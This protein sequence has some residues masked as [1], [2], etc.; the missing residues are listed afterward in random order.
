MAT[1]VRI[2][3]HV[4]EGGAVVP[5]T[6]PRKHRAG[7]SHRRGAVAGSDVVR[8]ASAPTTRPLGSPVTQ[9][10]QNRHQDAVQR[11]ARSVGMTDEVLERRHVVGVGVQSAVDVQ[12]RCLAHVHGRGE[13]ATSVAAEASPTGPCPRRGP[14]QP[15]ARSSSVSRRAPGRYSS[16]RLPDPTTTGSSERGPSPWQTALAARRSKRSTSL[17]ANGVVE[18]TSP[19]MASARPQPS[20]GAVT[21]WTFR[22]IGR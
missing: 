2:G 12:L 13:D 3:E 17:P 1:H 8:S 16:S 5:G 9:P 20:T 4:Q 11:V 7:F 18:P 10:F 19:A 22:R 6:S 14:G 21:A 15:T